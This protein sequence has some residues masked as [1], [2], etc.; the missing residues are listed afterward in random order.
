MHLAGP[1]AV[2]ESHYF[3]IYLIIYHLQKR[4]RIQSG[5]TWSAKW[6]ADM[7]TNLNHLIS[8]PRIFK[9][10]PGKLG[11]ILLWLIGIPVPLLLIFFLL[12]GCT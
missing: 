5:G 11:W 7:K 8:A 6:I 2:L 3:F 10:Q 1:D 12:R 4:Q 9:N